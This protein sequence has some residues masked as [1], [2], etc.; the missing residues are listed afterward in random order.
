M[1]HLIDRR[2]SG[3]SRGT[4]LGL[5]IALLALSL[6]VAGLSPAV[7]HAACDGGPCIA[8]EPE[9]QLPVD[10][11]P[12][13][14]TIRTISPSFAWSGDTITL[15]GTGFAGA[16]ATI[17]AVH[18]TISSG[19]DTR[20]AVIVPTIHSTVVGPV[21]IPVVVSSPTGTASTS[22]TLSPTLQLSA[23]ATFGENAA[24]GPDDGAAWATAT[25]D[26]QSGFVVSELTIQN[27][28]TWLSLTVNMSTV[29]LDENGKVIGYTDPAGFSVGGYTPFT[30]WI[31]DTTTTMH[32]PTQVL[33]PSPGKAP[34][35]RS[36][37]I[38]LV[39]DHQA[40]LLHTLQNAVNS[41]KLIGEVV[42]TIASFV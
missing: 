30:P 24:F 40:E 6:S 37:R 20:L 17:N 1:K 22:F 31:V 23:S 19:T 14:T 32:L 25:I 4:R 8:D 2:R 3:R 18:A 9:E 41:G 28:Q 34:F 13:T 7:A 29:W 11:G 27:N 26:R 10:P 12:V 35:A 38:L 36:V 5:L 21:T 15:T 16:T 33:R 39:R 42:K